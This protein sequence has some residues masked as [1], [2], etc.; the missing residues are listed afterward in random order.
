MIQPIVRSPQTS[1][2]SF[3]LETKI[4]IHP[5]IA[6]RFKMPAIPFMMFH[7]PP[8]VTMPWEGSTP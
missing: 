8:Q 7:G 4:P 5:E 1:A 6:S 2:R 3:P